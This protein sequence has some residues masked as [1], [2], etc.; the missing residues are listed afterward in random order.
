MGNSLLVYALEQQLTTIQHYRIT[1]SNISQVA[2]GH[3]MHTDVVPS[4]G[5]SLQLKPLNTRRSP[6]QEKLRR[7]C[8]GLSRILYNTRDIEASE[9]YSGYAS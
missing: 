3:L 7:H 6:E 8:G 4:I 5:N 2:S 9:D 1:F